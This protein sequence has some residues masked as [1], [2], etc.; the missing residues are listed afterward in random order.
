M[1]KIQKYALNTC[2]ALFVQNP[3]KGGT[4]RLSRDI[5]PFQRGKNGLISVITRHP[6]FKGTPLLGFCVTSVRHWNRLQTD[7]G[8]WAGGEAPLPSP[9]PEVPLSGWAPAAGP[10]CRGTAWGE[11]QEGMWRSTPFIYLPN[12]T[13]GAR[14][15]ALPLAGTA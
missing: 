10:S 2:K 15:R 1:V 6:F 8:G 7:P 13:K 11:S 4:Y 3:K 12:H 5:W 14:G 9:F